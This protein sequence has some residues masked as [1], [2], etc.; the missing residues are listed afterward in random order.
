MSV[1]SGG[2]EC[3]VA[4]LVDRHKEKVCMR[5]CSASSGS[6]GGNSR[7]ESFVRAWRGSAASGGRRFGTWLVQIA[8]HLAR[9]QMREQPQRTVSLDELR[10]NCRDSVF[11]GTRS[12]RDPLAEMS[13]RDMIER[14][15]VALGDLPPSYG[16]VFVLHHIEDV[17]YEEIASMTGDSVGSLKVR[18]H[19]AR[20][21]LKEAIS[22]DALV[23]RNDTV[24]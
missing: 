5:F 18:A 13:N 6:D 10:A 7:H 16:E 20:M 24:E 2:T 23:A 9:D 11:V 17:S 4:G 12:T 21:L 1:K 3:G 22:P 14:L 8:I 15:E 19:R